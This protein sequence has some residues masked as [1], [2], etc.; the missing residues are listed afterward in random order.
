MIEDSGKRRT[1]ITG[2]VR[3]ISEGKGR[4]DLLPFA[5]ILEIS[6]LYEKGCIKYGERNY[7]LGIPLYCY[8]DSALRHLSKFMDG[9]TDEPH[10]I[11]C[12]WNILGFIE[13][14]IK[15]NDGILPKSLSEKMPID[16]IV[17]MDSILDIKNNDKNTNT[18]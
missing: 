11:Q 2:A 9:K 12:A 8:I 15:I 10:I 17:L 16:K 6:K 5:A 4:M 1:F 14:A 3:D 7:M 18:N 13:T